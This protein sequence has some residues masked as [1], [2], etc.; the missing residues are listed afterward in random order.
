[1]L[2]SSPSKIHEPLV[3]GVS[4]RP[5]D[6]RRH[7]KLRNTRARRGTSLLRSD[8]W[9]ARQRMPLLQGI[10]SMTNSSGPTTEV[11]VRQRLLQYSV[12][13]PTSEP[14]GFQKSAPRL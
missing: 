5:T 2:S 12:V 9:T 3:T 1:M 14:V 10:Q 11:G 6:Q 13:Y 7:P 4:P 8:Y